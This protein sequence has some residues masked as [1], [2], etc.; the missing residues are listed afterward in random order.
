[1]A[2][3]GRG[4]PFHETF[5]Y[6]AHGVARETALL[7]RGWEERLVRVANVNT[8]GGAGLCLEAHDLAVSNLAAG[9][10]KDLEFVRAMARRGLVA[11]ATLRERLTVTP[12]RAEVRELCEARLRTLG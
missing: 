7:P 3:S 2:A 12:L 8:G 11:V 9:R 10:E 1:M 5:G 6:Y 4:A